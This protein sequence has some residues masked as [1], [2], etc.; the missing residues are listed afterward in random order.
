LK[1]GLK[2]EQQLGINPFKFGM[3]GSTDSHTSL[4]T[5]D[6]DNFFGKHSGNEPSSTRALHPLYQSSDGKAKIMGW[7]MAA[8][9]YAAVWGTENTR[10]A[11]FGALKRKKS[12]PPRVR[13]D[14]AILRRIRLSAP[15]ARTP[16][17][18]A[19]GYSRACLWVAICQTHR[20]A[21]YPVSWS[22]R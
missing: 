5:A 6:E 19:V 9:G 17:T 11:I 4:A 20:R 1:L 22:L 12:T 16:D 7:E 15:N 21:R 8:S 14:R 13:A 18:A 2:L 10:A 3:I